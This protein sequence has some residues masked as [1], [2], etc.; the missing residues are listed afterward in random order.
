MKT[1]TKM[2]RYWTQRGEGKTLRGP[3]PVINRR[4][5]FSYC[6]QRQQ[7]SVLPASHVCEGGVWNPG[8]RRGSKNNHTWD[9]KMTTQ[10]HHNQSSWWQAGRPLLLTLA[11]FLLLFRLDWKGRRN[12][13][14]LFFC[15][16]CW[17][18]PP[19]SRRTNHLL[20][21]QRPAVAAMIRPESCHDP[22]RMFLSPIP[23]QPDLY[24]FSFPPPILLPKTKG[25]YRSSPLTILLLIISDQPPPHHQFTTIAVGRINSS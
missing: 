7:P 18:T 12:D 6:A 21:H 2:K 8:R 24:L 1:K 19:P 15:C 5:W 4:W 11:L 3:S 14:L 20:L 16:C 23:F 25:Q 17:S 22:L 9:E 13:T 10:N